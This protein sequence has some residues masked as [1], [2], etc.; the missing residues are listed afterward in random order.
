MPQ[1][2]IRNSLGDASRHHQGVKGFNLLW[3]I[4]TREKHHK[5]VSQQEIVAI[6]KLMEFLRSHAAYN[7][8]PIYIKNFTPTPLTKNHAYIR[9]TGMWQWQYIYFFYKYLCAIPHISLSCCQSLCTTLATIRA[10]GVVMD[11]TS[12][13]DVCI[14]TCIII[15][16][17]RSR[18]QE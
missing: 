16:L 11:P 17:H 7:S 1:G 9:S 3:P 18:F 2:I 5:D 8:D 15:P 13:K 4:V 6:T 12:D 14:Y 10:E